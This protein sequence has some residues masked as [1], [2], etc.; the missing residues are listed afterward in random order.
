[1]HA[2]NGTNTGQVLGGT[3]EVSSDM[4]YYNH[5]AN[6]TSALNFKGGAASAKTLYIMGT[7]KAST[8]NFESAGST[9]NF[10]NG[11]TIVQGASSLN[12]VAGNLSLPSRSRTLNLSTALNLGGNVFTKNGGTLIINGTTVGTGALYNGTVNP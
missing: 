2:L 5:P 6:F 4:H 3:I 10:S 12:V 8:M 11:G 1:M 9:F 7:M